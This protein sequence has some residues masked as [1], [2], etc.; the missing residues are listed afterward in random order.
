MTAIHESYFPDRAE[1]Q[2]VFKGDLSA[3]QSSA[4]QAG[5]RPIRLLSTPERI[6]A[7]AEVPDGPPLRF[8]WRRLTRKVVRA[9]GPERI[10]PEW[11]TYTA[12]LVAAPSPEGTAREWLTP[13]FDPRAD[14]ALIKK[15]RKDLEQNDL[16]EVVRIRPRARDYYRVED[17]AGRRY[18]LFREGLYGD[19]RGGSPD[20]FMHGLFS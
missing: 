17:E 7:L 3:E 11:W 10:S 4:V 18:W 12:P 20:W 16:G 2:A 15:T 14:A 13:K 6:Q 8:V 9:D 19:G 1:S 5:P